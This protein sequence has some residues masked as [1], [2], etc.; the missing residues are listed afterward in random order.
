MVH[1]GIVRAMTRDGS[2]RLIFAETTEIVKEAHRLHH[3]SKTMTAVLGRCLTGAAMMGSLLKDAGDSLTLGFR[4][5]GPAGTVTCVSDYMGNVRIC[6]GDPTVELPP[7][8]AGKLDVGGAI[9][10]GTMY[11]AREFEH[12]EPYVGVAPIVSGEIAED[13]TSYY[14]SSEQTPTVCAL[15]VRCDTSCDCTAS[16]GFLLQLLPGAD[17]KMIALLERNVAEIVSI[18]AMAGKPDSARVVMELIFRDIPYDVFDSYEIAYRCTCGRERYRK[19]LLSL[20]RRELLGLLADRK[21]VETRCHFCGATYT[22]APEEIEE[23]AE[24]LGADETKHG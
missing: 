21:P 5:D 7:N 2:A 16:G 1:S 19:A 13:I 10:K 11:V 22:F 6:A 4:G 18:S 12:G 14:A 15:G 24:S 23:M 8:A 17:E 20:G 9:G 3:T